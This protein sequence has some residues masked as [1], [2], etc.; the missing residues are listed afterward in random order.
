ML[1]RFR[2]LSPLVVGLVSPVAGQ[3]HGLGRSH[4]VGVGSPIESQLVGRH[5]LWIRQWIRLYSP[6]I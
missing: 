4:S 2:A 3:L 1:T 5:D 6:R